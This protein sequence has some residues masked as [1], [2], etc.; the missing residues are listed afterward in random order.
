MEHLSKRAS[1]VLK[2]VD[3]IIGYS[4]YVELIS[5][6]IKNKSIISTSMTKEIERVN[7][8]IDMARNGK[9][10]AIISSG[11]PGIYAMAGLV[12]DICREKNI[13]IASSCLNKP[14]KFN[15][16]SLSIEVVPGIPA[17]CFGASLLGAP[18]THDFATI[19]LS[20]LLTPWEVIE[21]RL[22]AAAKADFVIILYNPKSKKR[23]WQLEKAQKIILK[24]RDNKTPVG[25]VTS[26]MRKEQ[27]VE[28]ITLD[29]LHIAP[30]GMQTTV[31]IGNTSTKSYMNF[32]V[33]P[34][35]YL[36]KYKVSEDKSVAK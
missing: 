30:V 20:N 4:T 10:C 33:T 11:D 2:S 19:S 5:P 14:D 31:F 6:L 7:E 21:S 16:E 35:G 17:L 36:S 32:M 15:N 12:F 28:I 1:E 8:A 26:A 3:T 22:E 18:L 29:N 24:H 23:D 9:P 13:P 25:I 34:R 27:S